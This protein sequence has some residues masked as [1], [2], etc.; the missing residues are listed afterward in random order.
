MT[1]PFRRRT[2]KNPLRPTAAPIARVYSD[3]APHRQYDLEMPVETW[4]ERHAQGRRLRTAVPRAALASWK[5]SPRRVEVVA[6]IERTCADRLPELVPIRMAR[7]AASRFGFLRGAAAIMAA[8]LARAP[9]SGIHVLIDGDS[10]VGNFGL[11]GTVER[12]IVFDLNDFDEATVGPFEWD[13]KRLAASIEVAGRDIGLS[14]KRRR[15]AVRAAVAGYRHELLRLERMSALDVW[16]LFLFAGR[17]NPDPPLAP[18]TRRALRAAA[19]RAGGRD[20]LSLLHQIAVEGRNGAWRLRRIPPL[21]TGLPDRVRRQVLAALPEYGE[22]LPRERRYI[23]SRY[24]VVDVAQRVVGVGSVGT[25]DYVVLLLGNDARDPLFLQIKEATPPA[26]QPFL[27]PLAREFRLHPGKR[28]VT[29][30]RALNGSPDLLLGWT[31][32]GGR[33]FYVRQLRNL[34]G[35]VPLDELGPATFLEYV[36]TCG[37]ILARAH[38]RSGDAAVLAGYCGSSDALDRAL[39]QFAE[40]YADQTET[41]RAALGRAIASGR[42][43]VPSGTPR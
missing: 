34:K 36:T 43:R 11:F 21:Q 31:R 8:D 4:K 32:V 18:A 29:A 17:R 27:P 28:V 40:R 41:D 35:A 6:Q 1:A 22:S 42:I 10:H 23:L 25:R 26:G 7:M 13:L 30:Q 14:R 15:R 33:P 5:P 20:N 37:A 9:S 3:L 19:L 39:G 2:R 24:R 38:A 16:Y 12:D